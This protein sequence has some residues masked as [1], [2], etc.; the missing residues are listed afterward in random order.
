MALNNKKGKKKKHNMDPIAKIDSGKK[1]RL[2]FEVDDDVTRKMVEEQKVMLGA[3]YGKIANK[4][5]REAYG[6]PTV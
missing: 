1:W 4:R 3:D 6:L 5:L 2:H